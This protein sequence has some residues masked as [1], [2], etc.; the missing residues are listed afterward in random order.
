MIKDKSLTAVVDQQVALMV[1]LEDLLLE[2][3]EYQPELELRSSEPATPVTIEQ[4]LAQESEVIP[5]RDSKDPAPCT[6]SSPFQCLLFQAAGL[7]L[8]IPLAE[9]NGILTWSDRV[10]PMPGHAEW[11]LGVLA[12][13]EQQIKVID[14]ALLV[15]PP[16]RRA[17]RGTAALVERL[18]YIVLIEGG[19]W[20]LACDRV[21]QVITVLPDKV[22]WRGNR[23]KRPWLAGTLVEHMCALLDARAFA[24]MLLV[25]Q[26]VAEQDNV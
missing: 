17:T 2:V 20:G 6:L 4:A 3:P 9:L 1:Y 13:R 23:S 5:A 12:Q 7:T 10:T 11:F 24:H 14:T 25:G 19:K 26:Q 16:E 8:A 18:R 15:I 21:T 22:K